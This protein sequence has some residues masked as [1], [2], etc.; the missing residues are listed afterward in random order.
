MHKQ[1]LF[2]AVAAALG[3]TATILLWLARVVAPGTSIHS[4]LWITCGALAIALLAALTNP[5]SRPMSIGARWWASVPAVLAVGVAVLNL[6]HLWPELHELERRERQSQQQIASALNRL[7]ALSRPDDGN[8]SSST[9]ERPSYER[10][11][12]RRRVSPFRIWIASYVC[13]IAAGVTVL[14][15]AV[16]G[17]RNSESEQRIRP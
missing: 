7:D 9:H 14:T 2:T 13:V 11:V 15:C 5:L 1:R 12:P 4:D 10:L 8:T 16:F 6:S 17:G 3:M